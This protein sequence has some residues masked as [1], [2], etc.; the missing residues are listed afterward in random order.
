MVTDGLINSNKIEKVD[1]DTLTFK[2]DKGD[3][4]KKNKKD[5]LVVVKPK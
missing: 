1:G 4:Y 2:N 3:E 5:V